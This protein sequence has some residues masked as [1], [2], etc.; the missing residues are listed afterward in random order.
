MFRGGEN[1]DAR[2]S[3]RPAYF[4]SITIAIRPMKENK[5]FLANDKEKI[6]NREDDPFAER[7]I[8]IPQTEDAKSPSSHTPMQLFLGTLILV[9]QT[10]SG[11]PIGEGQCPEQRR[12]G[13]ALN[14]RNDNL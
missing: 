1:S 10:A 2:T 3:D 7:A 9:E 4:Q 5:H 13:K 8:N 12:T 11:R 6:G 14:D